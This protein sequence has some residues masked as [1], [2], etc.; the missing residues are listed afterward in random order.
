MVRMNAIPGQSRAA[1]TSRTVDV[2]SAGLST[3]DPCI[4]LIIEKSS[5]AIC[6]APS[7]PI[8]TPAC[9][10]ARTMWAP[11]TAAIRMKS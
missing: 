6:E 11:E 1:S 9:D 3:V 4:D 8:D 7:C 10:P 2:A 5:S